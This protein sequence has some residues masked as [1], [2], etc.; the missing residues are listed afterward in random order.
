[1]ICSRVASIYRAKIGF[2]PTLYREK[3]VHIHIRNYQPVQLNEEKE[4]EEEEE[5]DK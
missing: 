5:E 4:E 3:T 2:E 1:M